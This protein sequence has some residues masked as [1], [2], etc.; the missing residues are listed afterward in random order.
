MQQTPI[1]PKQITLKAGEAKNDV[2]AVF[3]DIV[4]LVCFA[5]DSNEGRE[6]DWISGERGTIESTSIFLSGEGKALQAM[7]N[8]MALA[9]SSSLLDFLPPLQVFRFFFFSRS[10]STQGAESG[11]ESA[12]SEQPPPR[13]KKRARRHGCRS[14]RDL[15]QPPR[16]FHFCSLV[17]FP[18]RP[19]EGEQAT[20]YFRNQTCVETP[21]LRP[22]FPIYKEDFIP[23]RHLYSHATP[24]FPP[25]PLLRP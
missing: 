1:V 15:L 5:R 2:D 16:F 8:S 20:R 25:P 10:A 18:P 24:F 7:Q 14:A 4:L 23:P 17:F 11:G 21:I 9:P 6:G 13:H 3:S 19:F 12:S 22:T